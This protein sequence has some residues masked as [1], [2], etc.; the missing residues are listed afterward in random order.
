LEQISRLVDQA[1][2]SAKPRDP[3]DAGIPLIQ[4]LKMTQD[5]IDRVQLSQLSPAEK[6]ELLTNLQTKKA[7]FE[8]AANLALGILLEASVDPPE[9]PQTGFFR[10]EQTFQ[11]AVPGQTFT[12]TARFYDRGTKDVEAQEIALDLPSGFKSEVVKRDLK[13]LHSGDMASV[14]FRVTVPDDASYTAPYWG[15]KNPYKEAIDTVANPAYATLPLPPWPFHAHAVYKAAEGQG[16]ANTVVMAKYIDPILGQGQHELTVA[17][18]LSVEFGNPSQAIRA[19]SEES[20]PVTVKVRSQLTGPADATV[21]MVLPQSWSAEPQSR[22]VH[23]DHEADVSEAQFSIHPKMDGETHYSVR[24][25]AD[26]QGKEFTQGFD[27]V[28]R[29]DLDTFY[30]YYPAALD[31][32]AVNVKVPPHLRVGYIMGAG[33]EIPAT[34]KQLGIDVEVIPPAALPITDLS[35]FHTVVVGI[36]GYDVSTDIRTQSAKLLNYASNG[37]T[38]VVQYNQSFSTF[39]SGHYTPYPATMANRRVTVEEAPVDILDPQNPLLNYPNKIDQHDFE[40]WVQERGLYFMSEW[41]E[42][43]HPL[44]STHDPGEEPLKG[45]LLIAQYGKGTYIYTGYAFFRQLPAGVPGA[46]RLFMNLLSAG[47]TVSH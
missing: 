8:R 43:F 10:L 12:V 28:S 13:P 39:N 3:S 6:V 44:L 18:A 26:S 16:S 29:S 14:Q 46:I 40:N 30:Y 5:L 21:R 15:R 24:A 25:V 19:N 7:Q 35:Q 36:R 11:T 23:F 1:A 37:G 9:T 38:L 4:G 32:S 41:D 33:D 31:V 27:V 20:F 45:G 2:Q 34:L 17:P 47:K 22:A 42:H